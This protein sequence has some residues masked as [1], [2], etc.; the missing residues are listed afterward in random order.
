MIKLF[1]DH[2]E[3]IS[4]KESKENYIILSLLPCLFQT[5]RKNLIKDEMLREELLK[6]LKVL[7]VV[8]TKTLNLNNP[9]KKNKFLWVLES[10]I[11]YKFIDA[12]VKE[13]M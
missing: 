7:V 10:F 2:K 4:I 1:R 8:L 5:L 6:T 12:T 13:N 9:V 3:V 11:E